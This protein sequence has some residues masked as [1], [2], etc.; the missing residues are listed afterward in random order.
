MAKK[1]RNGLSPQARG[2][3]AEWLLLLNER[4]SDPEVRAGFLTWVRKSPENVHASLRMLATWEATGLL[5]KSMIFDPEALVHEALQS[6]NV[7]QFEPATAQ[8]PFAEAPKRVRRSPLGIAAAAIALLIIGAAVFR[9]QTQ[10]NTYSTGI[11]EQRIVPLQDGSTVVL[12]SQSR[13]RVRLTDAQRNIDLLE[14]Q[15]LFRVARNRV[16]PFVVHSG[17][18]NVIAV[19][20]EFDVYRK[21]NGTIVTVVEGTVA[22]GS[23][24]ALQ[25]AAG[26]MTAPTGSAAIG[27]EHQRTPHP[28]ATDASGSV[29]LS[30][31][32]QITITPVETTPPQ[33]ADIAT[34]T[35]WTQGKLVFKDTPLG[36]VVNE[37]NR[38]SSRRLVI[39]APELSGF[40]ITGVFSSSDPGRIADLLQKRFGVSIRESDDEIRVLPR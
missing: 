23:D 15:A 9:F 26:T 25:N 35:S 6:S 20:T 21:R 11:G 5:R 33:S 13:I 1:P 12:N 30:A 28:T 18:T 3:A 34:V 29:L 38:Y 37:F 2:D 24:R 32:E 27:H 7:V 16:R 31:G 10:K 4:P 14:G 17:T 39:D 8:H 36:D 19:G 22:V 40:H